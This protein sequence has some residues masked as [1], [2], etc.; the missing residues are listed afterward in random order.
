[1]IEQVRACVTGSRHEAVRILRPHTARNDWAC[2]RC[3]WS[4]PAQDGIPSCRDCRSAGGEFSPQDFES[5]YALEQT[6]SVPRPHPLDPLGVRT[7]R[8]RMPQLPGD[9]LR[10]RIGARGAGARASGCRVWG[11]EAYLEGL[12][13][14]RTRVDSAR[15]MQM[16]AR[17]VPFRGRV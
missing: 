5:L 12:Q 9:R 7:L 11:S 15:L 4:A 3:G 14:A 17:C 1:M 2:E 10:D 13:F 16:D 6:I 8:E